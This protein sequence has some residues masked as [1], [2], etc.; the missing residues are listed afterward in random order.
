MT[1]YV[2]L[3]RGINVGGRIIKMADLKTCFEDA[4]FENVKTVLQTGNVIF[5]SDS[6]SSELKPKIEKILETTFGYPAK[7]QVVTVSKMAEIIDGYPFKSK[8][9]FHNYVIFIENTLELELLKDAPLLDKK[10]EQIKASKEVVYWQVERG[11]TL[12]SDFSKL[13]SKSKYK[14]FNTNRNLNTL[15]KLI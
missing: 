10:M 8:D 13:L 3:L 11:R 7:V 1:R 2:A 15:K 5:E 9:N 4:G 6:K 12:K 14:D